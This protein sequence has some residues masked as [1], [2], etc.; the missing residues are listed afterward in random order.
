[1]AE[2]TLTKK[3]FQTDQEVRWCPGCGDYAILASAQQTFADL[4]LERHNMVIV[5]GI[6]CASRFPYYVNTYGFHT[7][8]GRAPAVA[9]GIKIANPELSVWI[10]AGDGDAFSIGGNHVIHLMRRNIDVNLLVFDNRIYGLTKGQYSPTSEFG[11]ITKST[12]YGSLDRPFNPA[13]VA[14][15]AGATFV[16]RSVDIYAPHVK[17]TLRDAHGHTGTSFVQIFQNCN[18][19]N[20]G[21]FEKIREKKL[22]DDNIIELKHGEPL[23]FGKDQD[24]GIRWAGPSQPEVVQLGNG[25]DE[26]DLVVHDERG[27]L[28]YLMTLSEMKPPD[29]PMP[30]GV[31]RRIEAPTVD[32]G[33]HRQIDEVT[34]RKGP[35]DL[36][37]IIY[38]GNIWTVD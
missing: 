8:H 37:E 23:I 34:E 22:R 13:S 19:F 31:L 25:I 3:D 7:V 12:P 14:L 4:G 6:G 2:A 28:G 38:S 9:S 20:D 17:Q 11:K 21:A 32:A 36:K 15:G 5:S 27:S 33:I 16:A 1:M 10:V 35:G 26:K 29:F 24:R 30:I 18:I